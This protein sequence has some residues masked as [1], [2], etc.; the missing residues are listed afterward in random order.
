MSDEYI[1]TLN[2]T[3]IVD[4]EKIKPVSLQGFPARINRVQ[5]CV[6]CLW[7][8][9]SEIRCLNEKSHELRVQRLAF[10]RNKP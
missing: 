4:Q 10:C 7:P 1:Q 2:K 9:S 3:S 5:P 6:L 8:G